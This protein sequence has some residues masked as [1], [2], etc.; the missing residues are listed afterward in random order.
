[1]RT[2]YLDYNATTPIA[3]RVQE[4]MLPLMAEHFGNPSSNHAIGLAARQAVEDART[5]VAG[6]LGAESSEITF[7]SGGT[8]SNNLALV[9]VL[10]ALAATADTANRRHLVISTLEHPATVEPARFL[11]SLGYE[12]T[13][14]ECDDN[15]MVSP[16]A[17]E[18]ALRPDTA[19]VSIMH[20]NNEIGSVQPIAEIS[21][22]CHDR[23]VLLHTD[24]AQSA[25]KIATDVAELGVDLLS[26]AGHKLYAPKGVGALFV[27][28]G[29]PIA[30]VLHGA[31]QESGLRPGTENVILIAGLGAAAAL[32]A[33]GLSDY[34]TRTA[35]LRDRLLGRLRDGVGSRLTINGEAAPRLPNTLS[36]NFPGVIADQLLRKI[37]E[38]CAAT[39]AACHSG[40][41]RLSVTLQAI[42]LDE[43]TARGTIRLSVGWYTSDEEVDRA[44]DWLISAWETLR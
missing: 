9:G 11:Q 44:A 42:G 12:L 6:L 29:T 27:R 17:V 8:E 10:R 33:E 21:A 5:R 24:A 28:R 35:A 14:V 20:A 18:A 26:I 1:M 38:L 7:T 40:A 32:A 34:G 4:A 19:L 13:L 25:G 43:E 22:V 2:I 39:G 37:P 23:S 30:P 15:G 36:V 41:T 31:G 16:H 3:P